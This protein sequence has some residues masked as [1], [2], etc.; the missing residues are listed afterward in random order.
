MTTSHKL[1]IV[2]SQDRIIGVQKL[3]VEND[4]YSISTS[5]EE[6]YSSDLVENGIVGVVCHVVGHD[7]GE[8][9]SS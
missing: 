7:G 2:K 1:L 6:L 4:F 5:V 3:G 9:V 8:G